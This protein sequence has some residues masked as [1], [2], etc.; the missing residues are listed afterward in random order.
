DEHREPAAL[1]AAEGILVGAIVAEVGSG[2]RGVFLGEDFRDDVTLV[3]ARRLKFD[4]AVEFVPAQ[5]RAQAALLPGSLHG[6][7]DGGARLVVEAA[8]VHGEHARLALTAP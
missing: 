7:A 5:V 2:G 8:P 4:P 6:L 3:A 1:Q